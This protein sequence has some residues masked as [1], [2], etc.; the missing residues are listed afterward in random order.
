[1]RRRA[2]ISL[3]CGPARW[4]QHAIYSHPCLNRPCL[5]HLIT[6][7][8]TPGQLAASIRCLVDVY[9]FFTAGVNHEP[10]RQVELVTKTNG[11]VNFE[12]L[13]LTMV[14]SMPD[15]TSTALASVHVIAHV[16]L[17]SSTLPLLVTRQQPAHPP[18][19]ILTREFRLSR[20]DRGWAII[21]ST[22]PTNP[23]LL[24]V[25]WDRE[26]TPRSAALHGRLRDRRAREDGR[27][28]VMRYIPV[29]G[30]VW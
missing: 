7:T 5:T 11:I 30:R 21:P 25:I 13:L 17:C 8:G 18:F 24:K 15:M 27:G 3:A 9:L 19:S 20:V 6:G 28:V 1:M 12:G 23:M 22:H 14:C 10:R 26:G 4:A 2:S 29:L 16:P